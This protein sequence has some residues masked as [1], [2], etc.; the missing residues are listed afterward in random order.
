M[1]SGGRAG[2]LTL[3]VGQASAAVTSTFAQRVFDDTWIDRPGGATSML[4]AFAARAAATRHGGDAL[5]TTEE[6]GGR[7][8]LTIPPE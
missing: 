5:W 8:R 1:P 4:G 6:Y 2:A 3:D 7:F